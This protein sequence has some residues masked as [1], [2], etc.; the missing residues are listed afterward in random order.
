MGRQ[1]VRVPPRFRHPVDENGE[2]IVGAHHE[3]L[4]CIPDDKK[5]AFQIYEN[6]SEG[7]PVSPIFESLGELSSWLAEQG[8]SP[9]YIQT[10]IADGHAPSF[11]VQNGSIVDA[12]VFPIGSQRPKLKYV[13]KGYGQTRDAFVNTMIYAPEFK[14]GG[15]T[16]EQA[17]SDLSTGIDSIIEKAKNQA[18]I[19]L[20]QQ[21]K[22]ELQ[23]V[24]AMFLANPAG[25]K[26]K[27]KVARTRLQRAYYDLYTKAGQ[28]LK[29]GVEI[30]PDDDV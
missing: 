15:V 9:S 27:R 18:A 4:H 24:R 8:A 17:F 14:R 13:P 19:E 7:S 10:L 23:A 21:C 30:G 1:I 22:V 26:E 3:A 5:T 28:L 25:D 2:M 16:F 6:V 12:T 20:L 29:P 11:V